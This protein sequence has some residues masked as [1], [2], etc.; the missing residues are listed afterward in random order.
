MTFGNKAKAIAGTV[1]GAG[2]AAVGSFFKGIPRVGRTAIAGGASAAVR[3][4]YSGGTSKNVLSGIRTGREQATEA[5]VNRDKRQERGYTPGKRALDSIWKFANVK[6]KAGGIG[7]M[8]QQVKEW[9]RARE[10]EMAKEQSTRD[11]QRQLLVHSKHSESDLTK[12]MFNPLLDKDGKQMVDK[13]T[14]QLLWDKDPNKIRTYKEYQ[15]DVWDGNYSNLIDE[16]LYNSYASSERDALIADQNAE[17]YRKAIKEN[18]D[19]MDIKDKN[20]SK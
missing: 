13:V 11:A 18:Q 3:G 20:N 2:G 9:T 4:A 8:D 16:G 5:R 17:S 12:A 19:I 1:A 15:R 14:G 7:E 6:N 10:N